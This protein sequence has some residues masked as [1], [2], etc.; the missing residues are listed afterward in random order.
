MAQS[1]SS[2]HTLVGCE[3][4]TM[5][6]CA[7]TNIWLYKHTNAVGVHAQILHTEPLLQPDAIQRHPHSIIRHARNPKS[8]LLHQVHSKLCHKLYTVPHASVLPSTRTRTSCLPTS[9]SSSA[10]GVRAAT[11]STAIKS[12]LPLRVNL[13]TT[14][15][16]HGSTE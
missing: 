4:L 13:S 10:L 11:L 14:Y 1:K 3:H 5:S 15:T 12:T 2:K 9:S 7:Y 8:N 16:G 6:L